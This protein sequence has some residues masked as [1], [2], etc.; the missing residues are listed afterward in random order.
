MAYYEYM[1]NLLNGEIEDTKTIAYRSIT[2]TGKTIYPVKL[3]IVNPSAISTSESFKP[4]FY[5][6][7]RSLKPQEYW[8]SKGTGVFIQI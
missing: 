6:F 2:E 8:Q 4:S 3:P 7:F 5:F 1:R